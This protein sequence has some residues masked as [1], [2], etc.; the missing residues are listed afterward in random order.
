MLIFLPLAV[1]VIAEAS[2]IIVLLFTSAYRA[3]VPIFMIWSL[4]IPLAALPTDGVLRVFAT[5]RFLLVNNVFR[6]VIVAVLIGPA[7]R[8]FGLP[9]AAM[10]TVL[11]LAV[12]KAAALIRMRPLL[13]VPMGEV[14]A[15]RE[16]LPILSAATVA[17]LPGTLIG[18]G[19]GLPQF[20]GIVLAG[21]LYFGTY[22]LL[23]AAF[24]LL[25]PVEREE[26][27]N[28]IGRWREAAVEM[29]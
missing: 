4:T 7:I 15:W 25:N 8:I 23:L 14:L 1:F 21:V 26:I 24:G 13:D 16:C 28:I 19:A 9:G 6:L 12:S 17:V 10:A 22:V 29:D 2:E 5:T 20:A 11:A 3:S 18:A 27:R